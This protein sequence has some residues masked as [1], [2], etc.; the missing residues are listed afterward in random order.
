MR[1]ALRTMVV[2][3]LGVAL[4]GATS[5]IGAADGEFDIP[6][7]DIGPCI[8]AAPF[9]PSEIGPREI[10]VHEVRKLLEMRELLVLRKA[11]RLESLS[12]DDLVGIREIQRTI[13]DAYRFLWKE[14]RWS[15]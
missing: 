4:G 8:A 15:S 9:L 5:A 14:G 2:V 1:V 7:L 6:V 11:S 12:A 10:I 13:T 3:F